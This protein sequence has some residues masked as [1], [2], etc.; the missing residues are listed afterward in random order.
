MKRK[1]IYSSI[2]ILCFIY[3]SVFAQTIAISE[4]HYNADSTLQSQD[5]VEIYNYGAATVDIGLWKLRDETPFNSYTIP[6]GTTLAGGEFLVLAQRLDTFLMIYPGVSNVIGPFEFGLDNG[7]GSVKLY[8]AST[9]IE[10]Q[11]NYLDSLPWPNA[12]DGLGP[13][14]EIFDYE[15][16]ENNPAN[17]FAGCV[18]GSPGEVFTTCDYDIIVSEINYNSEA[19]FSMGN[20][21]EIWNHSPS[22]IDVS[23]WKFRDNNIANT[24]TIPGGNVLSPDERLVICDSLEA[25]STLFPGLTNV[26]GEFNFGLSNNGDGIRLYNA[27]DILQYSVRYNDDAPWP[28]DADGLGYTIEN[29]IENGNPNDPATWVSGC[30]HGSPGGELI[31][32]CPVDVEEIIDIT[33]ITYQPNPFTETISFHFD[34][35]LPL[36]KRLYIINISG[37]YI[38]DLAISQTSMWDG[39]DKNGIV[40]PAGIYLL[41]IEDDGGSVT[42]KKIIKI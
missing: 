19:S 2:I 20:W 28:V 40:V 3:S 29:Y 4:I 17:W 32:P 8:N 39:K 34:A 12:A 26:V 10:A 22:T 38:S 15:G 31:L 27:E 14:L 7:G 23:N 9:V 41:Q 36:L 16:D 25:M 21:I 33:S 30:P 1:V 13:T 42:T 37:V 18:G 24:Y 5:W 11:V 35:D 6:S